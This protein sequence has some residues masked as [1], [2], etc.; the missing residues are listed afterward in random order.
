MGLSTSKIIWAL[1]LA[2][3]LAFT[4]AAM[5]QEPDY[6][7][8][9]PK[10]IAQWTRPDQPRLI[11]QQ[12][13]F[14]YMNGA[15]ELYL[16]YRFKAMQVFDY[17][18]NDGSNI[19][20]EIYQMQDSDDAF[21][22]LSQD[23]GGE[24]LSLDGSQP[25]EFAQALYGAGLL[26]IW[27]GDLYVR[28]LASKETPQSKE[29]VISLGR[30]ITQGRP[31]PPPPKLLSLLPQPELPEWRMRKDRLSFFRS[32]L[33]LNSAYYLSHENILNLNHTCSAVLVPY[34]LPGSAP[35]K[36]I[37]FLLVRYENPAAARHAMQVFVEQYL[38][39]Q[40]GRLQ[41]DPLGGQTG[42]AKIED[43]WLA[44][45]LNRE[46]LMIAFGAPDQEIVRR[47]IENTNTQ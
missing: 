44:C 40:A 46:Y 31:S 1:L 33:V 28:I 4:E 15:G 43:G 5:A 41:G 8:M 47:L 17:T 32:Y 3:L 22:L 35:P 2:G 34:E 42:L 39:D 16:S 14:K 10:N 7:Q 30:L 26:R 36:R 45:R 23:W 29:A 18:A 13:I 37:H 24:P 27:S 38:P 20:T 21:G 12:N 6:N 11:N 9:L 25:G 19:L